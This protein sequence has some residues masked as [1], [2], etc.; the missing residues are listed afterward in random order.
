MNGLCSQPYCLGNNTANAVKG[1][2]PFI[3]PDN[4]YFVNFVV[5]V[6][7]TG[8][9]CDCFSC[10]TSIGLHVQLMDD[11]FCG[12][13]CIFQVGTLVCG[14]P[15]RSAYIPCCNC[16][17]CMIIY[18]GGDCIRMYDARMYDP[19]PGCGGP[20]FSPFTYG[21][22]GWI[23]FG[24]NWECAI[25]SSR[26]DV[27][28]SFFWAIKPVGEQ[29]YCTTC[30][31]F[32]GVFTDSS[33]LPACTCNTCFHY[34][35]Y[36][37][38]FGQCLS[39]GSACWPTGYSRAFDVGDGVKRVYAS[40]GNSGNFFESGV[41][42]SCFCISGTCFCSLGATKTRKGIWNYPDSLGTCCYKIRDTGVCCDAFY[43][44][45]S[46]NY[47]AGCI[48]NMGLDDGDGPIRP[49]GKNYR[50]T[51]SY[52]VGGADDMLWSL[53]YPVCPQL[54]IYAFAGDPRFVIGTSRR[55]QGR[56]YNGHAD[57]GITCQIA[58]DTGKPCS[59]SS[60]ML[61]WC[62]CV[63]ACI[64]C[65]LTSDCCCMDPD[66]ELLVKVNCT[67]IK[68]ANV[69]TVG[70]S[71]GGVYRYP[72]TGICPFLNGNVWV[73]GGK[74]YYIMCQYCSCTQCTSVLTYVAPELL[75]SN[76]HCYWMGIAQNTVSAGGTVQVAIPGMTDRSSFASTYFCT[77]T[78]AR[79][80]QF[81]SACSTN[82]SSSWCT[83]FGTPNSSSNNQLFWY[84]HRQNDNIYFNIYYD[85]YTNGLVNQMAYVG[86][87]C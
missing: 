76:N 43:Y 73:G 19:Q 49:L 25:C 72:E 69:G 22:D 63:P 37:T 30:N 57:C 68:Y 85:C 56:C 24:G 23:V 21:A 39:G 66:A 20:G 47:T 65:I 87:C 14:L 53:S 4:C 79:S 38:R 74:S 2:K 15:W 34:P 27:S 12:G 10:D 77:C 83:I 58:T 1:F 40:I 70:G 9:A 52:S 11:N 60:P 51:R 16:S 84:Q 41:A 50:G 5:C 71:A 13:T 31:V 32:R 6:C 3:T 42:I 45:L 44:M 81:W 26:G 48:Q 61:C 67:G 62:W 35:Y 59:C 80:I 18:N 54:G 75:A 64:E 28:P 36:D 82:K 46:N 55:S 29:Q 7:D 78:N 8:N 33:Y 86:S 17:G